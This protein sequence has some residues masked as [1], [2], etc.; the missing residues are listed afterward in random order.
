MEAAW[1]SILQ[2]STGTWVCWWLPPPQVFTLEP[3]CSFGPI[4]RRRVG[5]RRCASKVC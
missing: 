2:M 3:L 4:P 5:L 1:N